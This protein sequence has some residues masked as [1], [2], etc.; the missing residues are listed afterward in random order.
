MILYK[1]F[2]RHGRLG[3][4]LWQLSFVLAMSS[5]MKTEWALPKWKFA[6]YFKIGRQWR[7][8]DNIHVDQIIQERGF[9]FDSALANGS[10]YKSHIAYD[11][12]GYFQ[13]ER[14]FQN[15]WDGFKHLLQ[16]EDEFLNSIKERMGFEPS[17]KDWCVHIRCGDYI[18]NPNYLHLQP[19]YYI[20][21]F[22]ERPDCTFYIFSNDYQYCKFHFQSLNNVEFPEKCDTIEHLAIMSQFKN[23]LISNSTYAWWGAKLAELYHPTKVVRPDGLF[24]G[25]MAQ[26]CKAIDFYPERWGVR[27]SSKQID[28]IDVTFV[29][30]VLYDSKDRKQNL[31]LAVCMLQRNFK[32][33]IIIGEQG[34]EKR[35]EYMSQWARYHYFD[36]MQEFHRTKMLNDMVKMATTPIVVNFDADVFFAPAQIYTAVKMIREG[37]DFVYPYNGVFARMDRATCFRPLSKIFDVGIFASQSF[38]GMGESHKISYGGAIIM[39]KDSFIKSGMEN[40]NFISFGREDV[41][42]VIRWR[43]LGY[44]VGRTLGNLYHMNHKIGPDSST[45]TPFYKNN[46]AEADKVKLMTKEE[47]QEYVS[48]WSWTK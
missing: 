45:Q 9:D 19:E 42:R 6:S 29:I 15:E 33:N 7:E 13:S 40:Q 20:S 17:E 37:Y 38:K 12:V 25:D 10:A 30:P 36:G 32:T 8:D 1:L 44:K 35:F 28:L 4:Q 27:P 18:S 3:N 48:N 2:Q 26:S 22:T 31:D 43:K 24:A 47:L 21:L 39:N 14:Y 23:H 16:F 11:F 5:K 34:G 46:E 41:E